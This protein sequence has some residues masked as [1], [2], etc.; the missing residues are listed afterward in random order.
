MAAGIVAKGETVWEASECGS[1][2]GRLGARDYKVVRE[3]QC[4][5][6]I[7]PRVTFAT[8]R[9]LGTVHNP[10]SKC[11]ANGRHHPRIT[12]KKDLVIFS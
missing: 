4:A 9:L 11:S 12:A 8:G 2:R 6:E 7:G 3:E 1:R 5:M 10:A